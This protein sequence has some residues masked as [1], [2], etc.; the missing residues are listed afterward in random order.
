M[1]NNNIE[2]KQEEVDS[3]KIT[4]KAALA[5]GCLINTN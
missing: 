2:I 5:K 1:E 4:M 3:W